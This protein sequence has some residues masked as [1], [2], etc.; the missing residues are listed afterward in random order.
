MPT[1][2]ELYESLPFVVRSLV[3]RDQYRMM[4]DQQRQNILEDLT[5]PDE[6]AID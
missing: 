6:D 2:D 4:T 3:T 5:L 1:L